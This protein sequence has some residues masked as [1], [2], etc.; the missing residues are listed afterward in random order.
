[1]SKVIEFKDGLDTEK[2]LI[3]PA[4]TFL[5]GDGSR[6]EKEKWEVYRRR[7]KNR[8]KVLR[9]IQKYGSQ[10]NILVDRET[11]EVIV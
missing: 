10:I 2:Y 1:M 5:Y 4:T 7:R 6:K 8:K 3:V 9:A 11:K